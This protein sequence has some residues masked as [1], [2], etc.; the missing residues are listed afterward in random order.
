MEADMKKTVYLF[1]VFAVL[2][3]FP[4]TAYAKS[5]DVPLFD[6][7][8]IFGGT[9]TLE[10][11]ETL[12]GDLVVI[13]GIVTTE[14]DSM[15]NGDV[16]VIGGQAEINGTVNGN[17]AGIG[18]VVTLSETAVLNGD[19]V[20]IGSVMNRDPAAQINGQQVDLSGIFPFSFGISEDGE[21]EFTLPEGTPIPD[22]PDSPIGRSLPFIVPVVGVFSLIS[23]VLSFLW[24]IFKAFMIAL[25]AVLVALF[26]ERPTERVAQAAVDE[27]VSTGGAGCLTVLLAPF[28][29]LAMA[30]T[31]IL[32]PVSILAIFALIVLWLFGWIAL[33]MET[34]RR[35]AGMFN[36][37]WTPAVSAG[38][39]TLTISLVL[40]GI[41]ALLPCVG[42]IP[43]TLVGTW[44]LGAVLLTRLGTRNYP[45]QPPVV[46]VPA[47]AL[48]ESAD[49]TPPDEADDAQ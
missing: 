27:P 48:P 13:G 29:L 18:G 6:D 35:M 45:Q 40:G 11:G 19:F 16:V 3:L 37:E 23:P 8:V 24:F 7:E 36:T 4:G 33:G 34:G 25:L 46:D 17:L 12:S 32:L 43:M 47:P 20:V 38:V 5:P 41:N 30:I 49:E 14:M 44:A 15:V 9:Y 21:P 2:M 42:W 10:S 31:L 39:G 22:L 28:V 1:F 26:L